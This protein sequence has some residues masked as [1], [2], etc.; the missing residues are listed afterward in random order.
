MQRCYS[1]IT[2][3]GIRIGAS[4]VRA[5]FDQIDLVDH[6]ARLAPAEVTVLVDVD[7]ASWWSWNRYA[8]AFA[9]ANHASVVNIDDG[10]IA[11]PAF[12]DHVA[13]LGRPVLDSPKRHAAPMSPTLTRRPVRSPVPLWNW[14]L[15]HRADDTRP[16]VARA[17]R[18]LIGNASTHGWLTPPSE[19]HWPP[20]TE[21]Q[22]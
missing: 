13:R 11:G 15:L 19:P 7:E 21:Q 2:S 22:A 8:S 17:T 5:L 14:A 1:A 10:G 18:T 9:E 20:V 12:F 6:A 4:E 3:S 16:I